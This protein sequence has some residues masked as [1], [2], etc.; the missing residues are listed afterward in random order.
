MSKLENRWEK[1][2]NMFVP[3]LQWNELTHGKI[4]KWET[5][6]HNHTTYE[7]HIVLEGECGISVADEEVRIGKGQGVVIAPG[8]YHAPS[9]VSQ[10]FSRFNMSFS[11]EKNFEKELWNFTDY[12]QFQV[13][14]Q[15]LGLCQVIQQEMQQPDGLLQKTAV[16]D[17]FSLL[18][19][20]IFRQ[21]KVSSDK[22]FMAG[23]EGE[24][25]DDTLI[26]DHFFAAMPPDKQTKKELAKQLHCSERQLLRKIYT[27][28]GISFREKLLASRIDR[29]RHLL[30]S[31]DLRIE[32]ISEAAGYSDS[33]A[34][35]KVFRQS[36]GMAPAEYRRVK[37]KN[38]TE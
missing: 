3:Y 24:P 16:T 22:K 10:T 28:Y 30:E 1:P 19:I 4:Q 6:R 35:Y 25:I 9:W 12:R 21:V 11:L 14:D 7:V 38:P 33:A 23:T 2:L 31:T 5:G 36:T 8:Q 17:L 34:F 27:Y 32:E 18:M 13:T 29:A 37:K 20:G 26:I 15:L